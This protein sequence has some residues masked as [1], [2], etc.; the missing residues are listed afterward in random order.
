MRLAIVERAKAVNSLI[1]ENPRSEEDHL[2]RTR[3][4][5]VKARKAVTLLAANLL[6]VRVRKA[7]HLKRKMVIRPASSGWP[8]VL[9]N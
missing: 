5:R 6:K 1:K 7:R 4:V 8:P 3:R 9:V 2:R